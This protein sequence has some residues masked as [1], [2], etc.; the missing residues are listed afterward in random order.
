MNISH[1][2]TPLRLAALCLATLAAPAAWSLEA[3]APAPEL[4]LPGINTTVTLSELKGKVVYLDFWAS[5]CGPCRQ[6]FPF[7]NELLAKY[8]AKGLEVVAINLDQQRSDADQFLSQVP[9][10][11]T[12]A[13]DA[14]GESARRFE[15]KGM[16]STFLIGRDGKVVAVHKGFKDDDRKAL[17]ASVV[18]AL[19]APP[20]SK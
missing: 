4:S 14:K 5:W 9:A 1:H 12:V 11:F 2:L 3:A 7:M 15:V 8:Q 16:P 20:A 13:F 6:S 18:Q 17:E 19:A 10:R